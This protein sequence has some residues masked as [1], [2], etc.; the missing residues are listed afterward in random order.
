[1]TFDWKKLRTW[2]VC[3]SLYRVI[4]VRDD[5]PE[6]KKEKKQP[7]DN[8]AMCLL[9]ERKILM[10]EK[11]MKASFEEFVD[12]LFHEL[13]HATEHAIGYDC[14]MTLIQMEKDEIKREMLEDLLVDQRAKA[15]RQLMSDNCGNYR[16]ILNLLGR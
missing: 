1:M 16:Y 8:I 12:T 2:W 13:E 10:S 3:G 11:I 4:K 9:M 6:L 7:G 14:I 5:H 15:Y